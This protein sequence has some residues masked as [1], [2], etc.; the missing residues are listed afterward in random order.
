MTGMRIA[1]GGDDAGFDYKAALIKDLK[2]DSRIAEVID[3]GPSS[4]T[5]KTAYPLYAVAAA[6]AVAQGRADR[7]GMSIKPRNR[8]LLTSRC[9]C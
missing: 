5:D 8:P 3:V 6:E 7:A 9:K 2:A 1:V 4:A